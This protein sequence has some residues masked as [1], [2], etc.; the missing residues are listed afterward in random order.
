ML[1]P[2]SPL[3]GMSCHGEMDPSSPLKLRRKDSVPDSP[4]TSVDTPKRAAAEKVR[5]PE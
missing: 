5:A 1:Y 4:E 2:F 3:S